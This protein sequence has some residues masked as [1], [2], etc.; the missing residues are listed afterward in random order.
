[1]AKKKLQNYPNSKIE[2]KAKKWAFI[3]GINMTYNRVQKTTQASKLIEKPKRKGR[4]RERER[5][6][7]LQTL[8]YE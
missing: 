8:L 5:E 1:V 4:E 3:H 2:S 6:S 7:F